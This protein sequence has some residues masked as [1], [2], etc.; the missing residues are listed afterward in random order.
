MNPKVI[1]GVWICGLN[2]KLDARP[3]PNL[4]QE[5]MT[6]KQSL[7]KTV[8]KI[9]N[10][11]LRSELRFVVRPSEIVRILLHTVPVTGI[12]SLN[13][14]RTAL[15]WHYSIVPFEEKRLQIS[16]K[17]TF[18]V[19]YPSERALENN[20]SSPGR[21]FGF[22]MAILRRAKRSSSEVKTTIQKWRF[23]EMETRAFLM[24]VWR[25]KIRRFDT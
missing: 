21:H 9:H 6:W 15:D 5:A 18:I 13:T 23:V 8:L 25:W 12:P 22:N 11:L 16:I 20:L 14:W 2:F 17:I 1:F 19:I 10:I 7:A 4:W 24:A 3:Y